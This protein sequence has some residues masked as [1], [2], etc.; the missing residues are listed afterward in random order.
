LNIHEIRSEFGVDGGM[1]MRILLAAALILVGSGAQAGEVEWPADLKASLEGV[2][3][4]ERDS[5]SIEIRGGNVVVRS[6]SERRDSWSDA[7]NKR[8]A[9]IG[10]F[11]RSKDSETRRYFN[12]T[13]TNMSTGWEPRPCTGS[14]NRVTSGRKH[15]IMEFAMGLFHPQEGVLA[16]KNDVAT[17]KTPPRNASSSNTTATT[18]STTPNSA[19]PAAAPSRHVEV[20]GPDGP[21]RLSP[22][23]AARNQ[24][25]ADEY[26]RKMDEHARA[27]AE[28]DQRLAQHRQNTAT[29]ASAEEQYK[30]EVAAAADRVAVHRVAMA[31]HARKVAGASTNDDPNI[32]IT[33]P[34]FRSNDGFPG[35]TSAS[36]INGCP[37]K[38]DIV[39]CLKRTTGDWTCVAKFGILTQGKMTYSSR[40][41][42]GEIFVDAITYGGG[43]KLKRPA[44]M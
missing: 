25:A 21:I 29:A 33:R 14:I 19:K 4:N 39:L 30:R 22:E 36:V 40:N 15:S 18:G 12:A 16:S 32:C 7:L 34:E 6:L 27:N 20:A 23:V 2:W 10:E 43:G 28:H 1:E 5:M 26:R 35:N 31:D 44:G 11:D 3:L 13:C 8:I 37:Q 38:V 41:A 17:R 9:T 24:A 42:T